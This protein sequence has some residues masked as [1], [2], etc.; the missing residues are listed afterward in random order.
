MRLCGSQCSAR[1]SAGGM[2]VTSP[3]G[4]YQLAGDFLRRRLSG[5][6]PD[7]RPVKRA[8]Q[9][10]P[11][12]RAVGCARKVKICDQPAELLIVIPAIP[13]QPLLQP[14]L[15]NCKQA[16]CGNSGDC[17][18]GN[19][20]VDMHGACQLQAPPRIC[21]SPDCIFAANDKLA[22][23]LAVNRDKQIF[24]G[25]EVVI[26]GSGQQSYLMRDIPDGS[27][28]IA[29]PYKQFGS[30][31]Q[32]LFLPLVWRDR[33]TCRSGAVLLLDKFEKADRSV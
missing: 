20:R 22:E 3:K 7:Q 23:S 28:A 10:Q 12:N 30:G 15:V 25:A 13:F 17:I 8:Q 9:C 26:D 16:D 31:T 21:F 11:E 18:A 6:V 4:L 19:R 2:P 32:D 33:L 29:L 27:T 24:L 1:V 5:P 14:V